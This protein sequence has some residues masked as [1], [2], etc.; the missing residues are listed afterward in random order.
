MTVRLAELASS[1][2]TS[3]TPKKY[4]FPRTYISTRNVL[5]EIE[6]L[7]PWS[8]RCPGD[9]SVDVFCHQCGDDVLDLRLNVSSKY[10]ESDLI[11]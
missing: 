1:T 10:E 6:E 11:H 8:S 3:V 4:N 2:V 9:G 7:V 5:V